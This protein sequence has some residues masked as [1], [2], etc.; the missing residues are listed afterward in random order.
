MPKSKT[1]NR[2]RAQMLRQQKRE[3]E[4]LLTTGSQL[5]KDNQRLKD[6][7]EKDGFKIINRAML[8]RKE[9]ISALI[10]DMVKP[11]IYEAYDE[12]DLRGIITLGVVAWNCGIIKATKGNSALNKILK[13]FKN[14]NNKEDKKLLD[15]YIQIKCN[16]YGQYN[17]LIRDYEISIENDGNLNF[18]VLTEVI[19]EIAEALVEP[20]IPLF[21]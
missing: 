15:E 8:G 6:S 17:D 19:D 11:L 12:E 13:S 3:R 16:K 5:E 1:K 10:L 4:R 18:T 14:Q 20:E 9:K 2:K 7:A 21:Y